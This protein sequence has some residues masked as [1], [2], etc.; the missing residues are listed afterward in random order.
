MQHSSS[1][2]LITFI[3]TLMF[4]HFVFKEINIQNF[5]ELWRIQDQINAVLLRFLFIKGS[6]K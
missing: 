5:R 1:L 4:I 2:F 3:Y 6:W